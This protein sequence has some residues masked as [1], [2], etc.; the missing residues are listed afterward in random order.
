[1][2]KSFEP[3]YALAAL[4]VLIFAGL[5]TAAFFL[6]APTTIPSLDLGASYSD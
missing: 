4:C 6:G 5:F 1:M 3:T 2:S